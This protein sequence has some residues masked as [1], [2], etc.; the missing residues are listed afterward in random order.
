MSSSFLILPNPHQ[1][2]NYNNILDIYHDVEEHKII[3]TLDKSCKGKFIIICQKEHIES[4]NYILNWFNAAR[5]RSL[6]Y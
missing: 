1:A 6:V 2:I 3:I 5:A 4:Y